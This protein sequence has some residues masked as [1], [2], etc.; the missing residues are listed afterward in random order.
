MT[1]LAKIRDEA[2]KRKSEKEKEDEDNELEE[3]WL[4]HK[5]HIIFKCLRD[6]ANNG[7][8]FED[9]GV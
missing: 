3:V 7:V 1:G 5:C 2:E 9:N 8:F 4:Y 6:L